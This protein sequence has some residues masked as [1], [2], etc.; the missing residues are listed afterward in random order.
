MMQRHVELWLCSVFAFLVVAACGNN[1]TTGG[2]DMAMDLAANA[3]DLS[4]PQHDLAAPPDIATP[5]DFGGIACGQMTCGGSDVCCATQV[6]QTAMYA[7]APSCADAGI[8]FNCDGPEDCGGGGGDKCCGDATLTGGPTITDCN[9]M[10]VTSCRA[11]CPISTPVAC[12]STWHVQLCHT[13]AD[14]N[15]DPNYDTC[16]IFSYNG[17]Q[18]QMCADALVRTGAQSCDM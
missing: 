6:G 3:P 16:C 10:A 7:C 8:V 11:T 2:H 4:A 13:S 14:C 17:N 12:P 5:V 9:I 1:D 15:A 18:V